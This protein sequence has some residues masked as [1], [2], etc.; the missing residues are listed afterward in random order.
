MFGGGVKKAWGENLA[1]RKVRNIVEGG[2][3]A[4]EKRLASRKVR[5][6]VGGSE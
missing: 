6:I 2:K 5:N 1:S 3:K 4:L